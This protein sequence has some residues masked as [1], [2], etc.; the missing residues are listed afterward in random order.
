L[1]SKSVESYNNRGTAYIQLGQYERAIK[2]L[3]SALLI[4]PAYKKAY[5]NRGY[6]YDELRQYER[7]IENYN[8]AINIDTEYENAYNNR[9]C[10][11]FRLGQHENAIKDFDR[12]IEINPKCVDVYYNRGRAY[13]MLGE[14]DSAIYNFR[15]F[16]EIAPAESAH[17]VSRVEQVIEGFERL[18]IQREEKMTAKNH[19]NSNMNKKLLKLMKKA[20]DFYRNGRY[21]DALIANKRLLEF[22]EGNFDTDNKEVVH[23]ISACLTNIIALYA[24]TGRDKNDEAQAFLVRF[25]KMGMSSK[26]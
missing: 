25:M 24:K 13:G 10:V 6:C 14:I 9:G 7:A 16:A 8:S 19:K 15:R 3:D 11:Y 12:V 1:D 23:M 18:K 21:E 26:D 4:N 17:L 20:N 5:N 2:D 22:I